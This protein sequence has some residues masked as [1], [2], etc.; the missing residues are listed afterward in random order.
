MDQSEKEGRRKREPG[1][2][3]HSIHLPINVLQLLKKY[4]HKKEK[5]NKT[6]QK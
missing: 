6:K 2:A 3:E 4:T 5:Q 1:T